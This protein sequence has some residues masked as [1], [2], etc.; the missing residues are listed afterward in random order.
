M[1]LSSSSILFISTIIFVIKVLSF[2]VF[3]VIPT[4]FNFDSEI[5][6]AT[7]AKAPTWSKEITQLQPYKINS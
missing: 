4:K 3:A 6:C 1:S 5:I 2:P 7:S